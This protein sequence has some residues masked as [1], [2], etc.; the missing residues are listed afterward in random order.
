MSFQS[1]EPLPQILFELKPN[2]SVLTLV[3]A[4]RRLESDIADAFAEELNF[5]ELNRLKYS[6]LSRNKTFQ[7]LQAAVTKLVTLK[8][9]LSPRFAN[10]RTGDLR[11]VCAKLQTSFLS[12]LSLDLYMSRYYMR[13]EYCCD[14]SGPSESALCGVWCCGASS[15]L[16]SSSYPRWY[17]DFL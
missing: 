3:L 12:G 5:A 4:I 17:L 14:W 11:C 8:M 7:R 16:S 10:Y 1:P 15:L 2:Y 13:P 6:K 9:D